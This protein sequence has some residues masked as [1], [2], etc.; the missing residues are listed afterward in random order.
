[1]ASART[2]AVVV[3][4]NARD[5]LLECLRSL[6]AD[7]MEEI[8]VVDNASRDGS[9]TA[10]A[11]EDPQA[12]F[13]DTGAN[14]GFGTA[15]NRG[16]AATSSDYVMILNPDAIVEPGG[17][18][19]LVDALDT[20]AAL[21]VVGPRVENPDGSLYP[22][23]R[24]FPDL[25]TAIGHAFLG[26]LR[27]ENRFTRDYKMLDHDRSRASE[28]DWISGTCML[29]RRSAFDEVGGFDESYFM[30]VED[31]D[32]CWRL[33]RAG[34][35]VGY[36]PRARVV[37]TIGASSELAPYRMIAAHHRSLYRFAT[38]TETGSRRA[39]LPVVAMGLAA[40]TVL[41]WVQRAYRGRPHA[42][43]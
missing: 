18:K 37:H 15:A 11:A 30:Y 41:A 6:R 19:M 39:L 22:S 29:V 3:N 26:F 4:Y 13:V 43:A 36:D 1:M 33:R 10:I 32:L 16:V 12:R 38:K 25:R 31:V 2:S 27:P 5:H 24:R 28:V 17:T 7:G 9:A 20:E 42:A 14:L 35:T 8:V 23:A 34:W 40:R 21:A